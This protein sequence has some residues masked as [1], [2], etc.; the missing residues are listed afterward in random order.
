M[1]M[2]G[3]E[4]PFPALTVVSRQAVIQTDLKQQ[5]WCSTVLLGDA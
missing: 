1:L 2:P 5:R 3:T 4:T